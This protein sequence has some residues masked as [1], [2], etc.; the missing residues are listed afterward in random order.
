[1]MFLQSKGNRKDKLLLISY[2]TYSLQQTIRM[3]IKQLAAIALEYKCDIPNNI[4]RTIA[5][6]LGYTLTEAIIIC[7]PRQK[8]YEKSCMS[9]HIG[10]SEILISCDRWRGAICY[11]HERRDMPLLLGELSSGALQIQDE[12]ALLVL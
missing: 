7:K 9:S 5:T 11:S 10:P 12:T 2:D 4:V 8:L 1:M 3:S 6:S